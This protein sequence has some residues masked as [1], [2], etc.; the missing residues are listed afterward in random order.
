[1]STG[2]VYQLIA[3]DGKQDLMLTATKLLNSRLRE[4]KKIRCK[5]PAIKDPLPTLIDIERTH[6]FYMSAHFKPFVQMGFEYQAV[7]SQDGLLKFGNTITFS[8]PQFGDFFHDMVLHVRLEGLAPVVPGDQVQYCEF[9]GHKLCRR[10]LFE[11][12]QNPIDFYGSDTLNMHYNFAVTQDKKLSW[13]RGVGQEVP[14]LATLYQNPGVDNCRERKFI[15]DGLQ[16]PKDIHPVA[17]LWIPLIFWFNNDPRLS[18]PSIAIPFGQRFIKITFA[19][20]NEVCFGVDFGGGGAFVPPTVTATELFINNIFVNPDIHDIFIK[21]V[22]FTMIRVHREQRTPLSTAADNIQL[23]ELKWPTETLYI[24][25]K[26]TINEG[27]QQHWAS[28]HFVTPQF[29]AFPVAI[30]NA[31]PPPPDQLAFSDATWF[32][33]TP[34]IDTFVLET[35]GVQLYHPNPVNFYNIYLPYRYGSTT[36][37]SP[38]DTGLY[39]ATFNL[40]PGTYQPS[41]HINLSRS[42]EFYFNYVSSIISPTVT[43]ALYVTAIAINFLLISEGQAVLRYNV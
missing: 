17:D 2:G 18:L 3:N 34:C 38:I 36:I 15:L 32:N 12:N 1:M 28:Y 21:R 41:G 11:V 33:E 9:L 43:A 42:R 14:K 23:Q 30:P 20:V 4:L 8:I 37:V 22:G 35:H 24:G 16:T 19:D 39:M 31:L 6:I 10:T 5:N 26:P 27:T 40:Y 25:I 29:W 7:Q 13:M